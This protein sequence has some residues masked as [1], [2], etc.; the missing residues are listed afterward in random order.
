MLLLFRWTTRSS[1]VKT[2]N[3][4]SQK[5]SICPPLGSE[6][7]TA[8]TIMM[9]TATVTVVRMMAA[10]A[11]IP[12]VWSETVMTAALVVARVVRVAWALLQLSD[13][14]G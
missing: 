12:S 4:K 2:S 5:I 7:A 11:S 3:P 1:T 13:E 10:T 14:G 9:V 8:V 6:K